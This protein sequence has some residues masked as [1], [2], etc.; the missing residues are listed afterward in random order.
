M[1]QEDL[2]TQ[3][4]LVMEQKSAYP[5]RAPLASPARHFVSFLLIPQSGFI[6]RNDRAAS[7]TNERTKERENRERSSRL[8]S[9]PT[10]QLVAEVRGSGA[11]RIR[12]LVCI[13]PGETP[14]KF[15]WTNKSPVRCMQ[16]KLCQSVS[17][18]SKRKS[19]KSS[20]YYSI[21]P[22][23]HVGIISPVPSTP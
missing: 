7:A 21:F 8:S 9:P 4:S 1:R 15:D 17:H 22:S 13:H 20:K 5:T 18:S 14:Q 2:D 23:L 3:S 11:L 12:G 6:H 19:S 16:I 10:M